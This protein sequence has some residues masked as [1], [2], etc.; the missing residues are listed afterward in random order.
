MH[1]LQQ[2]TLRTRSLIIA[3]GVIT[4]KW[5][6]IQAQEIIIRIEIDDNNNQQMKENNEECKIK[7]LI[8]TRRILNLISMSC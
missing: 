2:I 4:N 7:R 8:D 3:V 5:I 1:L 6:I